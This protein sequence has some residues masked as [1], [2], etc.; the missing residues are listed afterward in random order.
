LLLTGSCLWQ[1]KRRPYLIIGWLWFVGMLVPVIGL[2]QVGEQAHADRYT[3][4]P[5]TGVFIMLVWTVS[6]WARA[7]QSRIRWAAAMGAVSLLLCAGMTRVQLKVWENGITVFSRAV[8][9]TE[10]NPTAYNNLGAALTARGRVKEAIHVFELG[11][12]SSMNQASLFNV[13]WSHIDIGNE[14]LGLAYIARGFAFD[15]RSKWSE[16]TSSKAATSTKESPT[17]PIHR[18]VLALGQ[19]AKGHYT[20]AAEHLAEAARIAPHDVNARIDQAAYLAAAGQDTNAVQVLREATALAPT[21]AMAQANLGALLAK[22]GSSDEALIHYTAALAIE[23]KNPH[24]RHNYA[25]LLTRTGRLLDAK[26]QFEH[27]LRLQNRY[28]PSMQQL[29]WIH[30]TRSEFRDGDAAVRHATTALQI[31][32]GNPPPLLDVLAAA[33]AAQ[34]NY[35]LALQVAQEALN[36]IKSGKKP[37]RELDLA[38]RTRMQDYQAQ[39]PHTI[40]HTDP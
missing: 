12:K 2:V 17:V 14:A 8:S 29:A 5:L 32:G 1:A 33:H 15:P 21:N 36:S 38:I 7:Q 11:L 24:T 39:R 6:E 25:L 27:V 4:L 23:P 9:V 30:A 40:A 3:Y 13:G 31:V 35:P 10:V 34:G 22:R 19:A 16:N 20:E 18:K 37:Q 26:Q 28:W